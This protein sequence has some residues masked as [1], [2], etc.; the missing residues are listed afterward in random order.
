MGPPLLVAILAA[1]TCLALDHT[2]WQGKAGPFYSRVVVWDAAELTEPN[3]RLFYQQLSRELRENRAWTVD[4]FIDKNDAERELHGLMA[5]EGDYDWWLNL[6]NRF[7]RTLLPMA[8]IQSYGNNAV[9]RLRDSAG[10]C[11]ETVLSGDNFLRANVDN[12]K[13]EVLKIYYRSL[14]PHTEPRPGDETMISVYVRSSPFPTVEQARA[15]SQLMEERFQQKR[16]MVIFRADAFFLT[17]GAFPIMYRFDRAAT[18]PSRE[19]Y[20]HS[21]TMYCFC[22]QP[23]LPC[24]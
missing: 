23:G 20:A 11:S 5:T 21:K 16:V 12:A 17:D 10:K 14:P 13:F 1:T 19:E 9:L 3:L 4:V 6:Y 7:G 2:L 18:P 24:R 22:D 8:E 15:F